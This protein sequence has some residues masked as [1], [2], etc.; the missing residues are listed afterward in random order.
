LDGLPLAIELA[1][2]RVRHLSPPVLL[3]R[4]QQRLPLLTGG[5][6]D[7]PARQQTMRDTI[8]WS[9]DLLRSDE[10]ALFRRL[11]VFSGGFDLEAA[12]AV[13]GSAVLEGIASLVDKS[14]LYQRAEA[15]SEP[16]AEPRYFMLET[17]REFAHEQLQS[18]DEL[19]IAQERHA[20]LFIDRAE[21]AQ[22]VVELPG[23]SVD[24]TIRLEAELP[25]LRAALDWLADQGAHAELLRLSGALG[26]MW[27][28]RGYLDEGSKWLEHSLAASAERTS[29]R[30]RA[31]IFATAIEFLKGDDDRAAAYAAEAVD[32]GRELSQPTR[33]GIALLMLGQIA[34]MERDYIRAVALHE[35]SLAI[36]RERN[37]PTWVATQLT[38]LAIVSY[39]LGDLERATA[40]ARDV[41]P[42]WQEVE[43]DWGFG[44][45]YRLLGDVAADRGEPVRAAALYAESLVVAQRSADPGAV[46]DTLTG[47]AYLALTLGRLEMAARLF[48][49]AEQIY[50]ARGMRIPPMDRPNYTRAVEAVRAGLGKTAFEAAWQAG[51]G[52]TEAQAISEATSLAE[53]IGPTEPDRSAA[54]R[55]GLT[56]REREVLALLADG[57]SDRQIAEA[58]FISPKTVGLHVSNVLGKLGVPTRAA[59]I[60]HIHRHGLVRPDQRDA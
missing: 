8:G 18:S 45:A 40:L 6:V 33:V 21:R 60:A 17:V 44:F 7:Q 19:S 15:V 24:E 53:A 38:N 14:L 57:Q 10:Q 27:H 56:P 31:L 37:E 34:Q 9:Y 51:R 20:R 4:L 46:A 43:N 54:A 3:A 42:M 25:N 28:T 22:P 50:K 5:N 32:L 16:C 39:S 58:L 12:E 52:L 11:A 35:E 2:A 48:A 41:L 55:L 30:L 47:Y 1:A 59:A 36:F 49:T 23:A 13:C 26:H 29:E